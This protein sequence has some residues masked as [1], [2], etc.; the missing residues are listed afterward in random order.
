[1]ILSRRWSEGFTLIEVLV[2]LSLVSMAI[3]AVV[4]VFGTLSLTR[5]RTAVTSA[6]A[7]EIDDFLVAT[8]SSMAWTN[9]SAGTW[10]TNLGRFPVSVEVSWK[11]PTLCTVVIKGNTLT[12]QRTNTYVV[13]TAFSRAYEE[14][15]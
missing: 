6:L 3:L 7:S 5:E 2:A 10:T 1:M 4:G 15:F 8:Q 12:G 13:E 14:I 9:W 11:T